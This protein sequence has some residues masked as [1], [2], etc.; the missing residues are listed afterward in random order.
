MSEA[1]RWPCDW[2]PSSRTRPA[3]L[4]RGAEAEG[5]RNSWEQLDSVGPGKGP[6][7]PALEEE[8]TSGEENRLSRKVWA[9]QV[10]WGPGP[11]VPLE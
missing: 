7:R 5:G 6:L 1:A 9:P 8:Q 4:R 3:A 2:H 11:L 10:C